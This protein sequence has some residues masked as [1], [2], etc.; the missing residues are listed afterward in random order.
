MTHVCVS[1]RINAPMRR[2]ITGERHGAMLVFAAVSMVVLMGFLAMTLDIGAANRERRIAQTAAD[3]AALAGAAE[4][5][6]KIT[7]PTVIKPAAQAEALRNGF[8]DADANT[9]VQVFYEP[10]PSTGPHAGN[11]AYVE[12]QIDKTIPTIFGN[13]F[14]FASLTVHT[15]AVAGVGSY[16][17]NCIYSLDPSGPK[18]I[19]VQNGGELTTNCG[20]AINSTN[21]NALDVNSSGELDTQGGGISVSGGWTGNKTPTPAPSTGAPLIE[22]PLKDIAMPA[23]GA[24]DYNNKVVTGTETLL[25]GVYCGGITVATGSNTANLQAGVYIIVG[26]GVNVGN[27]GQMFGTSITLINTFDVSHPYAPFNFGTG[28]KAKL[29]APASGTWKGIL[30]F[31]DPAAPANVVNTFACASDSPPELTGTLYFPTQT[32]FFDGSNSGTKI[33]GTLIAK[34]VVVNGKVDVINETSNNSTVQRFT[35]VE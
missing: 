32:F 15:R 18:A 25:P 2:P 28:C 20:V 21:P 29:S 19:E 8:D 33:V 16:S 10:G 23:V 5:N 30:M 12:V 24:C 1:G 3:A 35:L 22:N 14:N 7:D 6:R 9:T 17:L 26:G 4:I 27:S 34:N 31:G 11:S 13:I